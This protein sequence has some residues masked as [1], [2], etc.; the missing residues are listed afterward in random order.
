MDIN[1]PYSYEEL[2]TISCGNI[3]VENNLRVVAVTQYEYNIGVN[4]FVPSACET[5]ILN[6]E[7]NIDEQVKGIMTCKEGKI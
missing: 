4:G 6:G 3:T 2:G 1:L 7:K 5:Y